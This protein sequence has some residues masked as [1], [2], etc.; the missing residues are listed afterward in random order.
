M[1]S[2]PPRRAARIRHIDADAEAE[3]LIRDFRDLAYSEA[4]RRE[5]EASSDAIAKDWGRVAAAVAHKMGERDDLDPPTRMAMNATLV[6][7]REPAVASEPRPHSRRGPE[8]EPRPVLSP[9]PQLFRV[10]FVGKTPDRGPTTLKE[11]EIQAADVSAAIVAAA[12]LPW[13]PRTVGLRILD[14]EGR[15]VFERHRADRR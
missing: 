12:N 5:S 9:R 15:E 10:Q 14:R 8:V 3:A 13:P 2:W 7:D 1:R 4:R 11:V 6:P